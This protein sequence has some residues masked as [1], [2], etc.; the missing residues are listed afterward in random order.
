MLYA[1]LQAGRLLETHGSGVVTY[2]DFVAFRSD[3]QARMAKVLETA[4]KAIASGDLRG[5]EA[6]GPDVAPVVLG[7]LRA[8]NTRLERAA[9]LVTS[10]SAF[11]RQYEAIVGATK[12]PGRQ[13]FTDAP[14]LIE[15]MSPLMQPDELARLRAFLALER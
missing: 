10:G 11:H 3:F 7:M 13:V 1:N 2:A 6:L 5:M 14:S 15:W 12:H 8:D 4:P 9:Y